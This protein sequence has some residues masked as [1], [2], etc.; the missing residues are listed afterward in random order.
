MQHKCHWQ[1]QCQRQWVDAG[2]SKT[3]WSA[4]SA[5]TPSTTTVDTL[6]YL[7]LYAHITYHTYSSILAQSTYSTVLPCTMTHT[8]QQTIRARTKFVDVYS[9]AE[10]HYQMLIRHQS[11]QCCLCHHCT[12]LVSSAHQSFT[13]LL[14][15]IFCSMSFMHNT[16]WDVVLEW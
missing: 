1:S 4:M 14:C 2:V 3:E 13:R 12:L 5:R 15:N 10:K 9:G 6:H 16:Y 11:T 8:T 7:A